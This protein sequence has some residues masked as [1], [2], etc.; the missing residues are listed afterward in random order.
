[1][2]YYLTALN[3]IVTQVQAEAWPSMRTLSL[4][5]WMSAV[6]EHQ[7]EEGEEEEVDEDEDESELI[8]LS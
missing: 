7:S 5:G 3:T 8:E 2:V 1:M 6:R 4:D